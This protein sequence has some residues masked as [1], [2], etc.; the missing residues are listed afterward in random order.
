MLYHVLQSTKTQ[1]YGN[2]IWASKNHT[3]TKKLN[4]TIRKIPV[5][6]RDRNMA[7]RQ[8]DDSLSLLNL[9]QT[10]TVIHFRNVKNAV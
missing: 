9:G 10:H 4:M 1:Q 5:N 3:L 6:H 8:S 2:G 7:V